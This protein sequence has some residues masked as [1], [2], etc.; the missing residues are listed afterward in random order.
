MKKKLK[1]K[2]CSKRQ[3]E[4]TGTAAEL[5]FLYP[6]R[7]TKKCKIVRLTLIIGFV[8]MTQGPLF[9]LLTSEA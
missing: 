8:Q 2:Q 6:A 4:H 3:R 7:R 5:I 1:E 9:Y